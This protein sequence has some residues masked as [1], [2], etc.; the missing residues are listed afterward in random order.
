M[1]AGTIRL[2]SNRP[3][4]RSFFSALA[5][6]VIVALTSCSIP[7]TLGRAA[8]HTT[9]FREIVGGITRRVDV[10]YDRAVAVDAALGLTKRALGMLT[11]VD[12]VV[13]PSP[14]PLDVKAVEQAD[15]ETWFAEQKTF[16]AA[17]HLTSMVESRG[18][19]TEVTLVP[20][21][22]SSGIDLVEFYFESDG[23]NERHEWSLK[24]WKMTYLL[25][26]S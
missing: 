12:E 4:R 17:T 15:D 22:F 25:V 23:S 14:C 5:V 11:N 6:I 18:G 21:A 10:E 13:A 19:A 26:T 16:S 7:S 9:H 20:G 24:C 3:L 1:S 8:T 2:S